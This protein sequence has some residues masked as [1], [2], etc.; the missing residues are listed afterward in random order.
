MASIVSG[1][2]Q[3]SRRDSTISGSFTGGP[4]TDE[5]MRTTGGISK[6]QGGVTPNEFHL[7]SAT[8]KRGQTTEKNERK[9]ED[10]R[11]S[12]NVMVTIEPIEAEIS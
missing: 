1:D 4:K 12:N 10:R 3:N 5:I 2:R 6:Y 11:F 7:K 9:P 8:E